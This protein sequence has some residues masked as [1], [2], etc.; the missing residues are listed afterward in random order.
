MA[1]D[2]ASFNVMGLASLGLDIGM[3]CD[4]LYSI[5]LLSVI[6]GLDFLGLALSRPQVPGRNLQVGLPI[7]GHTEVLTELSELIFNTYLPDVSCVDTGTACPKMQGLLSSL[8]RGRSKL[9]S[10]PAAARTARA[11][12][13][14]ASPPRDS[15][16]Q[17]LFWGPSVFYIVLYGKYFLGPDNTPGG[18]NRNRARRSATRRAGSSSHGP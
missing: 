13:T 8:G 1:H 18:R 17:E 15:D 3:F 9:A 5:L 16:P 14:S 10:T 2:R 11:S 7:V 12:T 6:F 4:L